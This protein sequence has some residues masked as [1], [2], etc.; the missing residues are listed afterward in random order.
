MD[1][2]GRV[3]R[4]KRR[5][6]EEDVADNRIRSKSTRLPARRMKEVYEIY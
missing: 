5:S 2:L 1:R 4:F 3:Y 6:T